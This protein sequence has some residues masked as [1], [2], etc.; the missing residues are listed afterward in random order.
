MAQET[1]SLPSLDAPDFDHPNLKII[2]VETVSLP[3]NL[4][5]EE[6]DLFESV[7]LKLENGLRTGCEENMIKT[8]EKLTDILIK[9]YSHLAA[10]KVRDVTL[11]AYKKVF[12]NRPPDEVAK[13]NTNPILNQ[14]L[15][16]SP[17]QP[18]Q[19]TRPA[20]TRVEQ[21]QAVAAAAC[22]EIEELQAQQSARLSKPW[23]GSQVGNGKSATLLSEYC[24]IYLSH[25]N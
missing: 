11:R 4:S 17:P 8:R 22:E 18:S 9:N 21:D 5:P 15:G 23:M 2:N 10:E 16:P 6:K 19:S 25:F 1:E 13:N 24:T 7:V 3:D 20:S 14:L 12:F